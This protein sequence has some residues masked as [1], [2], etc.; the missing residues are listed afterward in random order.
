MARVRGGHLTCQ[1]VRPGMCLLQVFPSG[2]L[3]SGFRLSLL[4]LGCHRRRS[5]AFEPGHR[6]HQSRWRMQRRERV[7]GGHGT[8]PGEKG[9]GEGLGWGGTKEERDMSKVTSRAEL[10]DLVTD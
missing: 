9:E 8:S 1:H 5:R 4:P 6:P 7:R 3:G 10:E 2:L